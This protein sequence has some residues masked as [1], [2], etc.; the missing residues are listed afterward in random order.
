[1]KADEHSVVSRTALLAI[2]VR[3]HS[4][5][6]ADVV[7]LVT[8]AAVVNGVRGAHTDSCL[9]PIARTLFLARKSGGA[10]AIAESNSI[11]NHHRTTRVRRIALIADNHGAIGAGAKVI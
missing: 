1:M 10:P 2:H 11:S 7:V 8:A 6:R 5:R 3:S 4:G 9:D